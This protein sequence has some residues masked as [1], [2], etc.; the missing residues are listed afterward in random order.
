M[1]V[2]FEKSEEKVFDWKELMKVYSQNTPLLVNKEKSEFGSITSF[3]SNM[4]CTE[5]SKGIFTY[6]ATQFASLVYL[7]PW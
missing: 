2:G 6:P 4:I 7:K 1:L 5:G 3:L